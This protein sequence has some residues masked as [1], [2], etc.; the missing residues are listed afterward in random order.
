M[1]WTTPSTAVAGSTLSAAFWNEQVRDNI[2][3]L[4]DLTGVFPAMAQIATTANSTI[5]VNATHS[6]PVTN[7]DSGGLVTSTSVITVPTAGVYEIY[8]AAIITGSTTFT[9]GPAFRPVINGSAS[10]PNRLMAF[11]ATDQFADTYSH[12]VNLGANATVSMSWTYG[13]GG[14]VTLYAPNVLRVRMVG[15]L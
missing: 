4:S 8:C 7:F 1:A 15:K 9:A 11:L 12:F 13:G 3:A 14:T 6:F 5:T 2:S 10:G